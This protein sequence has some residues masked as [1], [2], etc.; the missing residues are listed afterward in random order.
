MP[1]INVVRAL[2]DLLKNFSVAP[3]PAPSAISAWRDRHMLVRSIEISRDSACLR[4]ARHKNSLGGIADAPSQPVH[5]NLSGWQ[6]GRVTQ[7][8]QFR[9]QPSGREA[10]EPP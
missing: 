1:S 5:C 2:L 6:G 3:L 8:Y 9:A 10:G 4:A 7:R